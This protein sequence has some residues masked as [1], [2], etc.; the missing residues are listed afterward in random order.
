MNKPIL[1][2]ILLLICWAPALFQEPVRAESDKLTMEIHNLYKQQRF[3]EAVPLAEKVVN[4]QRAIRPTQPIN[5]AISLLNLAL[6]QKEHYWYLRRDL[7]NPTI[8][9][10][11]RST[12]F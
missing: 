1:T 8:V 9:N 2:V 11:V 3:D 12:G 7:S 4:I 5:L 10:G 6:L